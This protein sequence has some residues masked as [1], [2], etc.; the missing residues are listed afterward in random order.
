[1]TYTYIYAEIIYDLWHFFPYQPFRINFFN[2][3]S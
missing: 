2:G 3:I 1:M